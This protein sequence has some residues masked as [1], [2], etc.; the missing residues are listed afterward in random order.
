MERGDPR[1]QFWGGPT[2]VTST[3]TAVRDVLREGSPYARRRSTMAD[4]NAPTNEA[5][6]EAERLDAE[7]AHTAD[8]APTSEEEAAADKSK[9]AFAQDSDS[10]AEHYEEMSDIGANVK[11]EGAVE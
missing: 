4:D 6:Q 10:V 11:G 9:E 2:W 7:H 5:T 8:R 1:Q 3:A